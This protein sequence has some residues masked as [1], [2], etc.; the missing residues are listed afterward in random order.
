ME[1]YIV[2]QDKK[3][4]QDQSKEWTTVTISL[5]N[6]LNSLFVQLNDLSAIQTHTM[7][8]RPLV[9]MR[10]YVKQMS[11]QNKEAVT[12]ILDMENAQGFNPKLLLPLVSFLRESKPL[13]KKHLSCTY[14][15]GVSAWWKSILD[16]LFM[17]VRTAKPVF[18]NKLPAFIAE[19][20]VIKPLKE[21]T[22]SL[23][24]ATSRS[25]TSL[26]SSST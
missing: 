4:G 8:L 24:A 1:S 3:K 7:L 18:I 26:G 2:Y 19:L 23:S 25:T 12:L 13:F 11:L 15:V 14:I 6:D 20:P 22:S 5:N 17:F 10:S 9:L 21:S 16:K